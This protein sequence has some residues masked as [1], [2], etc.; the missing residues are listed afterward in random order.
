MATEIQKRN[1]VGSG[2]SGAFAAGVKP[3]LINRIE[4]SPD[5]INGAV[6]IKDD[7]VISICEDRF[8][9]VDLFCA[10]WLLIPLPLNL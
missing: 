1:G 4:G 3:V 9:D 5:E 6:M 7:G 8:A 10:R 2:L